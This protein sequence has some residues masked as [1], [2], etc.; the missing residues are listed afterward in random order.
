MLRLNFACVL[1]GPFALAAQSV[2]PAPPPVAVA[3]E[4][5]GEIRLDGRVD[6]AAWAAATPVTNFTQRDPHEGQRGSQG[7]EVRFLFDGSALYVGARMYDSSGAGGVRSRLTRRDR[8]RASDYLEVILDTYHDHL[9]RAVFRVNP[10]GVREDELAQGGSELDGSWDPIWEAAAAVDSLGWTAEMRIPYSQL[11]FSGETSQTWGLQVIRYINRLN[12]YQF[13]SFWTKRETGG[14]ARYGHLEGLVVRDRPGH[15]ELLP[16][17]VSRARYVRPAVAANPFNDGSRY[18]ARIGG[19]LKYLLTS[20]LTLDATFNPDFGQVEVD[21]AVVNLSQFETF[22]GEK[23]PFFIEGSGIFD[24]GNLSCHF[25]TNISGLESFYSRRIG[26]APQL[27]GVYGDAGAYRD[28]PEA[29]TIV[30]AAKVTGRTRNGYTVGLLDAVTRREH[31]IIAETDGRRRRVLAEPATNYFVG[32]AKR[33][34][35]GGDIVVGG[36]A[37]SMT[38]F[39]HDSTARARLSRHAELAGGDFELT[40]SERAYR[41]SGRAAISNVSGDQAAILRLQRASARYFQRPDRARRGNGLFSGALDSTLARLSGW[42]MFSRV[43]RESGNWIWESLT[44]VRS[45]GY[46]V[47]DVAFQQRADVVQEQGTLIHNWSRPTS[48]YRSSAL[49]VNGGTRWN[50]DRDLTD[51]YFLAGGVITFTNYWQVNL[52]SARR[53]ARFDDRATRGGPVVRLPA[54]WEAFA[55]METDRRKPVVL[56]LNPSVQVPDEGPA[57]ITVG[58][59]MTLRP[60]S[61]VE[62]SIGVEAADEGSGQQFVESVADATSAAFYGRRYVFA[63]LRQRTMAL[64]ARVNW[65]LRPSLTFE[66][67]AQPFISAVDFSAFKEFDAPRTLAKSV[68]GRDRGTIVPVTD[69][70]GRV[71]DYTID[72]DGPGAATAFTIGNPDFNF[73]SLRGNAVVRWEYRP[74]STLFL[75]WTQQRT[76]DQATGDFDLSRDRAALFRQR[77]DNVFL[78]KAS[79]WI[80]R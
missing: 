64:R 60:A 38:R 10:H 3:V 22:F 20:N 35:R 66:L 40:W 74:G 50:F 24:F 56:E 19:D 49:G 31:G 7:T 58:I 32:R 71:T 44:S 25:C 48:L 4:R 57:T 54:G 45:P 55:T 46:E 8:M 69:G 59:D 53:F 16:Y 39:G 33:D 43:A 78:V 36:I 63:E 75:V 41:W 15:L 67:F 6:D 70:T 14:P 52:F 42:G 13:L 80:G 26:R 61:N 1:A 9:G 47:N 79:Y 21:P 17:V 65:T 37:T 27:N 73:R 23:R 18:D 12:E 28:L 11:R 2:H 30:G 62:T 5:R 77:P 51:A 72:P 34:L 29:S 68:Y 76:G